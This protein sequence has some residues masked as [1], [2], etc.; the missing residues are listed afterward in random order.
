MPKVSIIVPVYNTSAYLRRCMDALT[1]QTLEDIE[2]IAVNDGSTDD[3]PAILGE[4]EQKDS[5]VR[6]FHKVNGGQATARNMG[7]RRSHGEYVGFAD[8]DDYV[9]ADMF[10]QMYE[11]AKEKD[12]DMV[13]C[14]YH[15]LQETKDDIR[16]LKTRGRIREY[17]GQKDMLIDPQVSPWNKLYRR[18]ILLHNGVDFPEGLIYED[19]A[20]YIKTIPYVKK[21]SYLDRA[22]VYYFLRETSTMNANKSRKVGNIFQVLQN[23]LDFYRGNG[24]YEEYAAELEYFCVKICLC[25]SLSRI[26]R[27]TDKEL[28]TKLLD[29]TLAFIH[30]NFPFYKKNPY[31]H[32]KTGSYIK[33][34]NRHN[35]RC[36]GRILGKIMKG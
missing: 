17:T 14:N 20:F 6:V 10:R 8:S 30:E 36:I 22:C 31:F 2:I 21:A 25:S 29:K 16:E 28:E 33:I 35:S 24:F 1:G 4:Y 32:G 12:C 26:G 18:E 34:V 11:L 5:R 19:T 15:Y 23:I 7:I 27:V 9:D 13:E 3:S